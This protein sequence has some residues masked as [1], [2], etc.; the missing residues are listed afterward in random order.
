MIVQVR[1]LH[2]NFSWSAS[3]LGDN[4]VIWVSAFGLDGS[5]E[6]VGKDLICAH[7][8]TAVV[9]VQRVDKS[10]LAFN[11][12]Y[13]GSAEFLFSLKKIL[14]VVGPEEHSRTGA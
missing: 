5:L 4:V 9:H 2:C 11:A 1:V 8:A 10:V 6:T 13:L 7:V 3:D 14:G 12:S